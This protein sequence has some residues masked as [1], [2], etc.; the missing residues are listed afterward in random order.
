[1]SC[2]RVPAVAPLD[3]PSLDQPARH[4]FRHDLGSECPWLVWIIHDSPGIACGRVPAVDQEP[5]ARQGADGIGGVTD[6]GWLCGN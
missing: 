4:S 6:H 2:E 5:V 3:Q 1:M